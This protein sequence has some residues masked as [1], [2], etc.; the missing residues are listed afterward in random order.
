MSKVDGDENE[1]SVKV[2]VYHF[3]MGNNCTEINKAE[4]VLS[5]ETVSYFLHVFM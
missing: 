4:H 3:V 5:C 2:K 1:Y